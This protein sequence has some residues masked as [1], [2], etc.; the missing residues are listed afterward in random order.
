MQDFEACE[1]PA[2]HKC[3]DEPLVRARLVT[4]AIRGGYPLRVD[5]RRPMRRTAG[6]RGSRPYSS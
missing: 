3:D 5:L 1:L 2:E 4:V 6:R